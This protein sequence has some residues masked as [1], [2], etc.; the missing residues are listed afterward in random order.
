V[1]ELA[2]RGALSVAVDIAAGPAP[3]G[4]AQAVLGIDIA[5]PEMAQRAIEAIIGK[6]GQLDGLVNI[7]GGFTWQKV[8]DGPN[9]EWDRLYRMNFSTALS[10]SRAALPHL[11]AAHGAIVN[12][13]AAA[14]IKAAAGMSAYAASKSAVAKLTESLADEVKDSRVR[15]N[16]VLPS[17]IDTPVNRREMPDAKFDRWVTPTALAKVIVFLL[18]DDAEAVTGALVPVTGRV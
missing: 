18:S 7:A 1:A 11:V 16:P 12:I 4:A 14:A 5:D 6:A 9:T 15:V 13:G 8:A 2:N 10:M 17:I 3:A